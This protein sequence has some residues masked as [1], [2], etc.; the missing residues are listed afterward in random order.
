MDPASVAG[1]ELQPLGQL[2]TELSRL[3]VMEGWSIALEEDAQL[4]P[5][6]VVALQV[7]TTRYLLRSFAGVPA[8]VTEVHTPDAGDPTQQLRDLLAVSPTLG[9]H[10]QHWWDGAGWRDAP[11]PTAA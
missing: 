1:V 9:S 2:S 3:A 10:L 7:G 4:G 6:A 11:L 8:K 5:L